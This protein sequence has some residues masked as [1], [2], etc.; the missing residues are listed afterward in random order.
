MCVYILMRGCA[1]V[2]SLE[3]LVGK[4]TSIKLRSFPGVHFATSY[5]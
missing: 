1:S 2:F 4:G 3:L 5:I